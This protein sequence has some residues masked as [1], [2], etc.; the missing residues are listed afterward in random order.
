MKADT[1]IQVWMN[2]YR[3]MDDT[4]IGTAPV[5]EIMTVFMTDMSTKEISGHI[6]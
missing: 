1:P 5:L 3:P 2:V 6:N 4:R